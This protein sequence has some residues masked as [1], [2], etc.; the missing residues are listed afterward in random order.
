MNA[1]KYAVLYEKAQNGDAEAMYCL[2]RHHEKECSDAA[3]KWL[4]EK[5]YHEAARFGH[6]GAYRALGDMLSAKGN[7]GLAADMWFLAAEKGDSEAMQRL[8]ELYAAEGMTDAAEKYFRRAEAHAD[9]GNEKANEKAG[10][11]NTALDD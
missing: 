3:G 4:A 5:F 8:G 2:G 9:A 1:T 10:A 6:P 11:D 7:T